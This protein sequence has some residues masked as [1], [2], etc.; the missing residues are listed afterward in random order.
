MPFSISHNPKIS[1]VLSDKQA[2]KTMSST[3]AALNEH[4]DSSRHQNNSSC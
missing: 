1:M 2:K 4:A 3:N